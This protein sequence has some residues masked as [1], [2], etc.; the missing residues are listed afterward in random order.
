MVWCLTSP[1]K[2]ATEG[3]E[4]MAAVRCLGRREQKTPRKTWAVEIDQ[5]DGG[6]VLQ[7]LRQE[8]RPAVF[9]SQKS[10]A[11]KAKPGSSGLDLW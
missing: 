11:T 2:E 4:G 8:D 7:P 5:G 1:V 10:Q 9:M 3:Q 6:E